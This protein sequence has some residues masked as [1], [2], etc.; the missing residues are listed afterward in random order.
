MLDAVETRKPEP[1]LES[2]TF[3]GEP[4][5]VEHT[6]GAVHGYV[7]S[8]GYGLGVVQSTP[9]RGSPRLEFDESV[10]AYLTGPKSQE[11]SD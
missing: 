1:P 11:Y 6:R 2:R 4:G 7:P 3:T 9:Q 5:L 8:N 10:W